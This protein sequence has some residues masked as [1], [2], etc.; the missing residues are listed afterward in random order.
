MSLEQNEAQQYREIPDKYH[1]PGASYQM[2][3]Y[4]YVMRPSADGV[5]GPIVLTL[6]PVAEAKGRTYFIL[7]RAAD[8]VNTITIQDKDDSEAWDDYVLISAGESFMVHSDGLKWYPTCCAIKDDDLKYMRWGLFATGGSVTGPVLFTTGFDVY[9][10]GQLDILGVFGGTNSVLGSGYSAKVGRFRHMVNIADRV[11]QETYGLVGQLVAKAATLTHLHSGLMGTFEANTTAITLLSDY[12]A[13]HAGVIARIGGH[14]LITAT[15]PLCGFL[16]FNNATGNLISG[17]SI[18]FKAVV[19]D[20]TYPWTEGLSIPSGACIAGIVMG[21]KSSSA[22]IGHHIG[23][24]NSADTAGDKAIAVFCDDN[25]AVLASDAQG[26]NSRCLIL[27]AQTGA[28]GMDALR[29][30]LRV[31]ASLTPSVSKAF[32]ATVG[33]LECSGTYTIGDGT[34]FTIAAAMGAAVETGGTPTIAANGVVCGIHITG[35]ELPAAPTGEALGI[36]FQAITQG[37]EHTFGFA[38]VGST[39]GNGLSVQ[40]GGSMTHTHKIA[41]W[42]N[43]VGTRYIG[44][45]TIA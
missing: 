25:N 31:V 3:T 35:K 36:L 24:Q 37:F 7:A 11:T 30:H 12:L 22:A 44:V 39:D 38:G 14:A 6:P 18:A 2:T 45:G 17:N 28:Y 15:T 23:V 16:A 21:E 1:D 20:N 34:N 41:V 27:A 40:T 9:T 10:D 19:R 4:D 29:G 43:G 42:I 33:Y 26:V 13:G 32:S 5:S 8:F